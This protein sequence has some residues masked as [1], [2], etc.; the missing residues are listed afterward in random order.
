MAEERFR[1]LFL[2][3]TAERLD[4]TSPSSGGA[5]FRFPERNFVEHGQRIQQKLAQTWDHFR[6]MQAQRTAVS[7]P[8][9][10]GVYLE[11]ESKPDFDL[12][13]KSLENR[14]SKIRLLNVRNVDIDGKQVQRATVFIPQ[15]K[16]NYF[17]NKVLK[18]A[19]EG[20]NKE[21]ISS[22]E[23]VKLAIL[24]SFWQDETEWMPGDDPVWCEVWLNGDTPEI[25][26][27]FREIAGRLN[28]ELKNETLYF[29]ER[30][31]ILGKANNQQLQDLIICSE[32]I[33]EFRRASET[34]RFFVELENKDQSAWAKDLLSRLQIVDAAVSVCILDGGVNNGHPLISPL[35]NDEDSQAFNED[36]GVG[37]DTGHG[38]GMAGIVAF[39]D[40]QKAL[41]SSQRIEILHRL[42]SLKIL[43]PRGQNDPELYG[44]ITSQSVSK[45]EIQAP[46]RKR[47]LCMAVTAPEFSKRDG[48]PSSWSGAIDE[49]TSGYLDEG[50]R[51]FFVSA[52]NLSGQ[53]NFKNYPNSNQTYCVEDPGQAWNA[54]TVGAYTEKSNLSD[55]SLRDCQVVA[56]KGGLS[57]FS[58]TS[59]L[60][61]DKKWPIK[62][63]IL[64]EGG[65]LVEDSLGC[66]EC[67]DLS[68]LTTY[69]K[70]AERHFRIFNATSAAT[71]QAAW[72][73]AQIQAAYPDAWPETVRA[74]LVHSSEWTPQ[75]IEQFLPAPTK[76]ARKNL[77]KTCGYGVPNLERAL[78]CARN[79]VNLIVQ[80][81]MQP[82]DKEGSRFITRDMHVHEI[83]WPKDV[84]L[85]L[86][87]TTI[88]MRVTLSYFIEPGPGEIGWKDRYRYAS[89]A[90]RFD[91]N[92]INEDI[93]N[94]KRR[95]NAAARDEDDFERD[96][97]SDRW[98][99]GKTTRHKGSIHSDIWEGNAADLATCNLIG[100][101]P[102]IGWWR[103]RSHLG[104]WNKSIRYSLIVSLHTPV[105]NID[106]YTPIIISIKTR[107]PVTITRRVK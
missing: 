83:P 31:V 98:I 32:N 59:L 88:K 81:G 10:E 105:Q 11:F 9:R 27:S 16:E 44:A 75:M 103:E 68:V 17:L 51:L 74:L 46:A 78:W 96:S 29:P 95:I 41:E 62:P 90:L 39:G 26:E 58:S 107:V 79:S 76:K 100:V 25:E 8:V 85:E 99:I 61:N 60:W 42:E 87:E 35:M 19:G 77:L 92:N 69:Y 70:P 102:A 84:L 22:I 82:Y 73:A 2:R 30:I 18:Y 5:K 93:D 47:I 56:P 63:E 54:I 21:L 6:D 14:R 66:L 57:P 24:E 12:K 97:G 34:A 4:F 101:Y 67:D 71:A 43:P 36:W 48:S 106:L 49:I 13:I 3:D 104:R 64:L 94:F 45:A 86:G 40:L 33:A 80:A 28:I 50:K 38:T 53:E 55:P 1:N 72:M 23:D 20:R 7:L 52:G 65:N 91:V 37:D 15:G 89:C